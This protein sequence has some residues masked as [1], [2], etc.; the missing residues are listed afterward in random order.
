[1]N[2]AAAP[3]LFRD[4]YCHVAEPLDVKSMNEAGQVLVGKHDLSSFRSSACQSKQAIKTIDEI[5]IKETEQSLIV[6][7]IKAPSFLHNQVRI[8]VGCLLEVGRGKWSKLSLQNVLI[9]KDRTKAAKTAPP[10]G[11]YLYEV[12]Y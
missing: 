8:I 11:L 7:Y 6:V 4:Y 12:E 5:S 3:A 1:M 10:H 9:A 2:R